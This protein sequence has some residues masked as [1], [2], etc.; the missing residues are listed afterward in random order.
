M[1]VWSQ[2]A[3]VFT[4]GDGSIAGMKIP[5]IAMVV[6]GFSAVSVAAQGERLVY[7]LGHG[8]TSV[9]RQ[10]PEL[11]AKLGYDLVP[12][13]TSFDTATLSGAR[14]LY[15]RTPTKPYTDLEKGAIVAFTRSLSPAR[16]H[17]RSASFTPA[18]A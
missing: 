9:I 4:P 6:L 12:V 7:D 15:L 18:R 3:R 10:M 13:A 8:Q 2:I 16:P 1:F 14:L 11:G 5:A 17:P